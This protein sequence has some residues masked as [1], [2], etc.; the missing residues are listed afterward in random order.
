M[1]I[2]LWIILLLAAARAYP[3]TRLIDSISERM[4][5]AAPPQ[6]RQ[7]L[8][9]ALSLQ[10]SMNLDTLSHY[11]NLAYRLPHKTQTEQLR[12]DIAR[13]F[14]YTRLGMPDSSIA[15]VRRHLTAL[16]GGLINNQDLLQQYQ[17][18][19]AGILLRKN[20]HKA[21]L[22]YYFK[23]LRLAT[24]GPNWQY[25]IRSL[26]GAGWVY[27][28][29][30]QYATALK[31]F[32]KAVDLPAPASFETFLGLVHNNMASCYGA[33]GQLDEARRQTDLSIDIASRTED[34]FTH[35]N[36]LLIRAEIALH[37]GNT[38]AAISYLQQGIHLRTILNDPYYMISDRCVLAD[39]YS[40]AGRSKAAIEQ[41]KEAEA[42]M[43]QYGIFA[44]KPLLLE[45]WEHI[46][47]RQ[48]DYRQVASLQQQRMALKDSLYRHAHASEMAEMEVRYE[49]ERKEQQIVQ[50]KLLLQQAADEQKLIILSLTGLLLLL[51]AAAV[52]L[53]QRHKSKTEKTQFR[54][55]VEAEQRERI[56]IARDLHDSIGQ[57]LSV[58]KMNLS[59][60]QQ[61][62]AI[63]PADPYKGAAE[64]V[65]ET[66]KEVRNISHNL[67]PEELNFGIISALEDLSEKINQTHTTQVHLQLDENLTSVRLSRAFELSMYRMVQEVTGNMLKHA[68]AKNI[69]ISLW[70]KEE[71]LLL[72]IRDDG[73]GFDTNVINSTKGLG[74]KNI[75]ARINLLNGKLQLYSD[76]QNGTHIAIT[77]PV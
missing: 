31:W 58:V 11:I 53:L 54:S 44:R 60:L 42:L 22:D 62:S 52:L 1:R 26:N 14:R 29:M 50:Q 21:A 30:G 24:L 27:M 2:W 19:Y 17:L 70:L 46:Y 43:H 15:L 71:K 39:I 33:L 20:N 55:I 9:Y 75:V 48:G 36:S 61:L 23:A 69:Y 45:T 18:L 13:V 47:Q 12:L 74:W 8:L 35:A 66:I 64:L 32:Q 59:S 57:K 72:E 76:R 77:L 73:R 49:A 25:Y 68:N 67:L 10:R 5:S 63:T 65:D 38:A 34:Y 51:S 56:R 6:Q 41:V 7:L 40:N 37:E 3:Q 16:E 4:Y 28:E